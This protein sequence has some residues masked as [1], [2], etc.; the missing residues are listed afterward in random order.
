[1]RIDI[2]GYPGELGFNNDLNAKFQ[3]QAWGQFRKYV[4]NL[5][6]TEDCDTLK[7]MSGSPVYLYDNDSEKW[8]LVG[9]HV[10]ASDEKVGNEIF[11]ISCIFSMD[12][13]HDLISFCPFYDIK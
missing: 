7:G 9:I 3:H 10:G 4:E 1:M 11:N 8:Y 5:A 13:V 2:T 12:I 6:I